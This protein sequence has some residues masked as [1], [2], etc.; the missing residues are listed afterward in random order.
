MF[1][2]KWFELISLVWNIFF[3]ELYYIADD[4][5]IYKECVTLL[6]LI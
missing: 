4:D 3:D 6:F 5:G 2:Y 1:Y